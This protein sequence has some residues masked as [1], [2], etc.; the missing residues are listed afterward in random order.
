[1]E[2]GAKTGLQ[3]L[4]KARTSDSLPLMGGGWKVCINI[5]K[6]VKK[7]NFSM[8]QLLALPSN[9]MKS[10]PEL[11]RKLAIVGLGLNCMGF[12]VAALA[13]TLAIR[14]PD[15]MH[16]ATFIVALAG[17]LPALI[18]GTIACI[19]LLLE[20]RWGI[21]LAL[22]AL[23]VQVLSIV[24]YGIVRTV[25]IPGSRAFCG[26]LTGLVLAMATL[27]LIYWSGALASPADNR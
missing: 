25:L 20:K 3:D 5:N 18:T 6:N 10:S 22:I 26:G 24:P 21:V 13:I 4:A 1:L 7:V 2:V 12:L 27:L 16:H 23:G 11:N 8:P 19:A 14:R 15:S 17:W 9:Q